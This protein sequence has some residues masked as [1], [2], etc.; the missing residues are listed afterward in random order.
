EH[1]ADSAWGR[2]LVAGAKDV[3]HVL[4]PSGADR[5]LARI[6]RAETSE[7]QGL[8]WRRFLAPLVASAATLALLAAAWMAWR[9]SR[10]AAP[11][12]A[13]PAPAPQATVA[14]NE[15]PPFQLP[16]QKPDVRLSVAALTFRGSTDASSL[17]DDLAPALD[18]FRASDYAR[19]SQMLEPLE[20]R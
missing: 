18:A 17:V 12:P 1:L 20:R 6:T 4:D 2:A 9:G 15:P 5:L 13:G 7:R 14:R 8:R 16:L 10:G 19:A 3:D 11:S